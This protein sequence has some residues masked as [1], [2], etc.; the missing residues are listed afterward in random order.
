M[1]HEA[2]A[3]SKK[4]NKQPAINRKSSYDTVEDIECSYERELINYNSE[5]LCSRRSMFSFW[6]GSVSFLEIC[7]S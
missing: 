3:L 7:S 6:E 2:N 5:E 1:R 4:F